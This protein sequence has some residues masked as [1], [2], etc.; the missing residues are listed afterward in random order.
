MLKRIW[1][2]PRTQ[3]VMG[4][5]MANYLRLVHGTTRWEIV[6]PDLLE[7]LKGDGPVI[8][9]MWH[10][11]HFL[12]SFFVP[13][14]VRAKVLISRHADG[15]LNAIAIQKLGHGLVRG[16]GG[17]GAPEK[18]R[19]RGGVQALRELV[20]TLAKGFMVAMTADVPKVSG[21]AG[22]GIVLLAKLSGRPI[23]PV[24]VVTRWRIRLKSWDKATIGL[25]FSRGVLVLGRPVRVAPDADA[26]T[27]EE[28][29]RLVEQELNAIHER[30]YAHVGGAP[31]RGGHG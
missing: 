26:A 21:I 25:P 12:V 18:I 20:R 15:E 4:G 6:T 11:Q 22:E 28:A 31:W 14:G 8:A 7:E 27:L 3:G 29:R 30:A 17:H 23:Y 16:S 5:L 24:A 19:K 9:G 2:S 1:R 10:G 13:E